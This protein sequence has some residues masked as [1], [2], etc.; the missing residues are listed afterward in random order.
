MNLLP[1]DYY[2]FSVFIVVGGA[3]VVLMVWDRYDQR[4]GK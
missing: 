1:A 3:L 4:R 2:L